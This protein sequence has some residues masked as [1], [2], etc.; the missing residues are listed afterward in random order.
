MTL[1]IRFVSGDRKAL[2]GFNHLS[3]GF[4]AFAGSNRV[5]AGLFLTI[6]RYSRF[7]V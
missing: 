7:K 2:I 6:S 4:V 3:E 1:H 5:S